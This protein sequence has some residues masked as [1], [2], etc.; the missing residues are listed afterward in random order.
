MNDYT[1]NDLK[2]G[3]GAQFEIGL[4]AEMMEKFSQ[5]SGDINPLHTN[6]QFAAAS[7]FKGRV[8]FGMLTS[9]F[10]SQLVGVY[11]PGKRALLHGIDIEFKAPAYAGDRLTVSGTIEFLSEPYKRLEL[12]AKIQNQ[13]GTVISKAKIRVGLHES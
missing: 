13:A 12:K 10:Y 1:W 4:A 3:L 6:D 8:A 9:A 5:L 7:G 2:L 11:L